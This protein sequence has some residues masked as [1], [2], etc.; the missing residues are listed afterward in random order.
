MVEGTRSQD[1]KK[2]E[3]SVRALKE[4]QERILRE[5]EE[6]RNSLKNFGEIK[7]MLSAVTLKYD[8]MAA[9][10][11]GRQLQETP[12]GELDIRVRAEGSQ[13]QGTT[14]FGTRYAK[15]DFPRFFGE[16]PT[17]WVYKCER[18]FEY[19][20]IENQNKVKLAILHLEDRALQWYQWFEKTHCI[21]NWESF[22]QGIVSR[23][24]PDVFEDAV[25]EL[26]KLKQTTTVK[27]FQE[28][29]ELLANKT[30]NLPE[31][32]FTSCFISGL[33][34]EIKANVLMFRPINITQAIGLA[35]LQ[36]NSIEAIAKKTKQSFKVEENMN[37]GQSRS[38]P[39]SGF[40][41]RELP[42]EL[43]EKKAK[44][45]CFRCNEKYTRG[46]QCK[47]K[48]LYAIEVDDGEQEDSEQEVPQEE[49]NEEILDQEGDLQISINA[50]TGSVS[51]RTM[52]VHGLVKKQKVI[53]LIDTG[54]THNFL[55]QEVVK[56]A[57][58]ETIDTDP[59]TVF[60]A[61][62]TKMTSNAACKGFKWEMQGVIFQTDMR[63]LELK[64]CDMVL[65]IQW[66]AT[67]GPVK[68]DFKNLSMDFTLNNRRHV[69]RGGKQGESKLV[70]AKH[71][72][73]LLQ[74]NP[75]GFV[76]HLYV[77]HEASV[78]VST[79]LEVEQLLSKFVAVFQEP[80]S[81]PPKRSHDHHIPPKLGAEPPN[82]RPYKCFR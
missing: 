21:I 37:S 38:V 65:G 23:F 48:Q 13:S 56:K 24:G 8:Q 10:V 33:K 81:L 58:V 63:I 43:E 66:L 3:E 35:K 27:E 5:N 29:F 59:L 55:N 32:F 69:L 30:Q 71:M 60:V 41:K 18:F 50:I 16:D 54:S 31:S 82:I 17:G 77:I 51:Y 70:D 62:G 79:I 46:H 6:I 80:K 11:Y 25:G 57:G 75:Q 1:F 42:K 49:I 52:R 15:I 2:L 28:Q 73:K 45:L 47:K 20:S 53:I 68:W 67:L 72:N 9:H 12:H 78:A 22:K 39:H 34:E 19:N 44:G 4:H 7:E 26:T 61:D 64:G 40:T 36:E 76:A 74:K 14:D